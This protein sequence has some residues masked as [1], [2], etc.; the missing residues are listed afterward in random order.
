[1]L[2]ERSLRDEGKVRFVGVSAVLPHAKQID[3]AC[4]ARS[5]SRTRRSNAST[6][7]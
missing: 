4:S 6:K 7:M 3:M 1:V 2:A 5:R